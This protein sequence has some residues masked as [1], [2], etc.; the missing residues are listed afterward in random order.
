MKELLKKDISIKISA[1][2]V[3]IFLW[4]F[5]LDSSANPFESRSFVVPITYQNTEALNAKG[6]GV[7]KTDMAASVSINVKGRKDKLSSLSV[8]D[9]EAVVD[10]SKIKDIGYE[11]VKIDVKSVKEGVSIISKR[12]QS[13]GYDVEKLVKRSF[14]VELSPIGIPKEPYKIL[15]M[16]AAPQ[17][18]EIEGIESFVKDISG[19][20]AE[21]DVNGL[22]NVPLM[23]V[24]CAVLGKNRD[25]LQNLTK[26][27]YADVTT[28]VGKLL[29]VNPVFTGSLPAGFV[30]MGTTAAPE[31]VL[32]TGLPEVLEKADKIDT[33]PI[34]ITNL[35]KDNDFVSFL[36]LPEGTRLE[37]GGKEIK[38]HVAVEQIINKDFIFFRNEVSIVNKDG[39]G[40]YKY[41]IIPDS[42]TVSLKGIKKDL[43]GVNPNTI[44]PTLDVAGLTEGTH[45]IPLWMTVPNL[46]ELDKSQNVSVKITK[47]ANSGGT[48]L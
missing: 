24:E 41:E 12:P 18:I 40:L 5:V 8:N 19:I 28:E 7:L 48:G 47:A 35:K 27:Y 37:S 9:F 29:R 16:E 30:K 34:N 20:R 17:Y 6:M 31:E 39:E 13:V 3:A 46:T 15:K 21:V 25:V 43:D 14:K 44:K 22:S 2:L 36:K 1:I 32:I 45:W 26:K 38:V 23:R 4:F 11:D 33:E 10:L 42:I